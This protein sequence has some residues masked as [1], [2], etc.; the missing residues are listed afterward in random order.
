MEKIVEIIKKNKVIFIAVII[1]LLIEIFLCNYGFFRTLCSGNKNIKPDFEV[2]DS[3]VYIPN[4]DVK[5]TSINFEY[6]NQ[7]TDKVTYVLSYFPDG[8][9][10]E[11]KINPK[12][13]SLKDKQ[14]INF[15]TGDKCK[16][17]IIE[18]LTETDLSL[19]S[20]ILNHPNMN[21]SIT[22]MFL[23]FLAVVFMMQ[24]RR[25][26]FFEKQYDKASKTD[27]VVF[28]IN[29][30]TITVFIVLYMISQFDIS[31]FILKP[32]EVNPTDCILLQAEA[33]VN[34]QI[35]LLEEPSEQL[36]SMKNPYDSEK[37]DNE[38]VPYLYDVTYYNGNYYSYFGIA[39]VITLILP[40]RVITG[41]YMP[42]CMFN[43]VYML[44]AVF[45]LYGLY[46][47]LVNRYIE[48]IS[49]YNFYLGFYAILFAS[50]IFTLFRGMKYD[51]VV[52]SGI[53]FL[54]IALNL[55]LSIYDNPKFKIPKLIMLGI[56]T[57]LIVLSKPNLIVYYL[58]ILFFVIC[59][60]KEKSTK[61][62]IKDLSF[63][64]VPL[65]LLAIFQMYL[66]YIRF[67]NILEFGAQYQLSGLNV[68]TSMGFS[69]TKVYV[70]IMEYLFRI[71]TINP[72]TFPFVF[73]NI[74]TAFTA[75]NE[76]CYENK[77]VGLVAVPILWAY[78]LNRNVKKSKELK[79]FINI[80]LI[81]SVLGMLAS[82]CTG[83]I[84]EV[85]AIDF[86]LI[87]SIGAVILLLKWVED[88]QGED[89]NKIFL[90]L[91]IATILLMLPL[92][93]TTES[94]FLSNFASDVSVYWKN[95]F[96]F[97]S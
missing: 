83:G 18:R 71:P 89:K 22:R 1:T 15:N 87:L 47:K 56:A 80:C 45:A 16:G 79:W 94:S 23:I 25:G 84:C 55:S 42:T 33:I 44:I 7:L 69:I 50:N 82:G 78:L 63:A 67:D 70:V 62:K 20:I 68:T 13:I 3:M 5:V 21:I 10:K 77:L 66:N 34:G 28:L 61:E 52:T 88:G 73:P 93:L 38:G 60:M 85:Y 95:V 57:A 40:F 30:T 36:K 74:D 8:T 76:V 12:I 6:T 17:I 26:S 92:S 75:I 91:C 2:S 35:E 64:L 4:I 86:K 31:G 54:L 96:E 97:W 53:A 14:Y 81:V 43:I 24:V 9:S 48:K 19:D 11:I 27:N 37:R 46:K 90:I 58:L 65:G 72:L 41:N 39:P 49:L 29:L 59:S 32:E 51:I